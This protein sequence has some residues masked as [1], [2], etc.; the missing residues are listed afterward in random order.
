M[1]SDCVLTASLRSTTLFPA[2]TIG[3]HAKK[4][5]GIFAGHGPGIF[6][7][8]RPGP[9]ATKPTI[10]Q[11][12]TN[13]SILM[14]NNAILSITAAGPGPLT[15]QWQ[16]NGTN[17]SNGIITAAAGGGSG[18][19]GGEATNASLP[20][21][22]GLALD[23]Y[24][25]LLIA[26]PSAGRVREVAA[27]GVITTVAGIGPSNGPLGDGGPA[28]NAN[29]EAPSGVAIDAAGDVF[30]ADTGDNRIRE[31][32]PSG[33]IITVAGGGTGGDGGPATNASLNNPRDVAVDAYG[34]LFIADTGNNRIREVGTNGIIVTVAGT[35]SYAYFGDGGPATNA[36]LY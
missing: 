15:Y 29:L 6:G 20:S 22:N 5:P 4:T 27:Y 26:E 3:T 9:R 8:D 2:E 17:I 1:Q 24:G 30:I 32:A 13:E 21:P 35:G 11:D 33:I 10:T 31:V 28:T 18:G 14:G 19:D 23:A 34:N 12:L 36:I 25:N 7:C 16:F